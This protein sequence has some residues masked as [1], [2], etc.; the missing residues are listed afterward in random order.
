M[1]QNKL[2]LE[3]IE[4]E[5]MDK[6][7]FLYICKY[8]G[9]EHLRVCIREALYEI[10]KLNEVQVC[11]I[12][13]VFNKDLESVQSNFEEYIEVIYNKMKEKGAE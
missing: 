8:N 1:G 5:V 3:A 12:F 13:D 9:K 7:N 6:A 2:S 11:K 10:T 4:K